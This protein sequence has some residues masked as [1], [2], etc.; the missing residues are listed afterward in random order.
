MP[1]EVKKGESPVTTSTPKSTEGGSVATDMTESN[2]PSSGE[3]IICGQNKLTDFDL[4]VIIADIAKRS[5][6]GRR[7][8][9]PIGTS[10]SG[11]SMFIASLLCYKGVGSCEIHALS[12]DKRNKEIFD[13]ITESVRKKG[14][15]L[16]Q[17]PEGMFTVIDVEM[18]VKKRGHA[19]VTFIDFAG[20]DIERMLDKKAY[21][22]EEES[23]K[24]QMAATKKIMSI[25]KTACTKYRAFFP[26]LSP[27]DVSFTTEDRKSVV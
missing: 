24:N 16:S 15:T 8:F 22:T 19:K 6:N 3:Y 10:Q 4:D 12:G 14:R 11:K 5:R 23:A 2:K 18:T 13:A 17:T 27:I 1:E 26:L 21:D 7:L 25:L 9:V 20:E